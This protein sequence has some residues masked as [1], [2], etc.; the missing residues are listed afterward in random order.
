MVDEYKSRQRIELL[1]SNQKG[2]CPKIH[3]VN[4]QHF[5]ILITIVHVKHLNAS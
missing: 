4:F 2:Y 3:A 1:P 5:R